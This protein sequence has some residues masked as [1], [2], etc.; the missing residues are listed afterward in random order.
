MR[1]PACRSHLINS[2]VTESKEWCNFR[3]G[4]RGGLSFENRSQIPRCARH[5]GYRHRIFAFACRR[6][7]PR[8]KR[9]YA[10]RGLDYGQE[11]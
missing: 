11:E 1:N 5:R 8:D 7:C 10:D 9:Y 2:C 6:G 4:H 3:D